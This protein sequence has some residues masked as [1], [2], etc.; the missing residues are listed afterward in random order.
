[1]KIRPV[2]NWVVIRPDVQ[3]DKSTG[4]IF[5]PDAAKEKTQMG[6][7]LSIGP[8]RMKEE[9]DKKGKVIEKKFEATVV[10]SGDH[11]LYDKYVGNKIEADGESLLLVREDNILGVFGA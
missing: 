8:G 7:V 5:I 11:V 1:M 2:N 10:K 4:G 6:K 9:Q 3:K